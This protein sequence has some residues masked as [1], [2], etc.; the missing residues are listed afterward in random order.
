MAE[1]R[2]ILLID[3]DP[4]QSALSTLLLSQLPNVAVTAA[5]DGLEG[6]ELAWSLRPHVI[7]L[8]LILPGIS[9]MELLRRYRRGG[10]RAK[11]LVLTQAG[12]SQVV[13]GALSMGADFLLT[14]PVQPGD[15]LRTVRLLLDSLTDRCRDLLTRMGAPAHWLGLGQAARCAALLGE[16]EH[17]RVLLK[18]L[19]LQAAQEDHTTLECV[20]KNI[21]VLVQD[22]HHRGSPLYR[23]LFPGQ[24]KPPTN[25]HFLTVLSTAAAAE[26]CAHP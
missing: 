8:D 19:Y 5:Y 14:K 4:V 24:P 9:G 10:G 2:P 13:A 25:R 3:A 21:R 12:H 26:A 7:L 22:L 17:R 6:L 15:L 18:E 11:L 1:P 16:A 23:K 20:E